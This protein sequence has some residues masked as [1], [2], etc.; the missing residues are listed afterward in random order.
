MVKY[1]NNVQ[2]LG[3]KKFKLDPWNFTDNKYKYKMFEK[4]FQYKN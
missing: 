4:E 2:Q 1:K 3:K